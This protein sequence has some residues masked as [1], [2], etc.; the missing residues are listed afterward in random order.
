MERESFSWIPLSHRK[1]ITLPKVIIE[2]YSNQEYGGVYYSSDQLIIA[3]SQPNEDD[4]KYLAATL[5]HEFRH[6]IQ[7][8]LG[9][10]H[11]KPT[12][13]NYSVP[14]EDMI[15]T[16]FRNSISEFDALLFEYKHARCSLNEWWLRELVLSG[17]L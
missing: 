9:I 16:Y 1:N 6:H 12:I 10:K 5:T 2:D 3:L 13:L 17:D 4:E 15:K 11:T 8:S 14:Y 7:Y